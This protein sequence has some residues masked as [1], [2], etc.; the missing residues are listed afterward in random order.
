MI[1]LDNYDSFTQPLSGLS[2]L[3]ADVLC[4]QRCGHGRRSRAARANA[5][6]HRHFPGTMYAE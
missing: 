1:L 4:V 5:G 3:G 6:R 2:E